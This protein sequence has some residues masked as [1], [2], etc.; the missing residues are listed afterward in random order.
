MR[1]FVDS[2]PVA[3]E[4]SRP[5]T[6]ATWRNAIETQFR[7]FALEQVPLPRQ[8]GSDFEVKV[9][10]CAGTVVEQTKLPCRTLSG[11]PVEKAV[12]MISF[13]GLTSDGEEPAYEI[14]RRQVQVQLALREELAV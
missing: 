3:V 5:Q 13:L 14:L 10:Y 8:T 1:T 4:V 2:D 12:C 6:V 9:R 7:G 11:L